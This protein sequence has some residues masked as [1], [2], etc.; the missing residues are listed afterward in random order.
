M[1]YTALQKQY[2]EDFDPKDYIPRI[3]QR[4][5][6]VH[7]YIEDKLHDVFEESRF[8][9]AWWRVPVLFVT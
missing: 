2:E 9:I 3:V 7:A 6:T 5:C 1:N 4:E 8:N